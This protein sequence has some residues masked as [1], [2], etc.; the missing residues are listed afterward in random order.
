MKAKEKEMSCKASKPAKG[1]KPMKKD[2]K[3][4]MPAKKKG[5]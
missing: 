2:E 1:M 5:Y 4:K 3:K